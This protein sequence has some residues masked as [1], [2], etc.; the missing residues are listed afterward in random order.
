MVKKSSTGT[1]V[2][3]ADELN[4]STVNGK[5]ASSTCPLCSAHRG[6]PSDHSLK[7]DITTGAGFCHHCH[8]HVFVTDFAEKLK[9]L[10]HL[11]NKKPEKSITDGITELDDVCRDYLENRS[12][13]PSVAVRTGVGSKVLNGIH[14]LAFP[15]MENGCVVNVQYKRA[16][17]EHKEFKFVPGAKVI[18]WNADCLTKGD[19]SSPL[20]ITEGMMDAIAL[21]QSGYPNVVSV[22]NGAGSR[23]QVFDDYRQIIKK[24]FSHIVFAGDTD[25]VGMKLCARVKDYFG[26]EEVSVVKWLCNDFCCKDANDMLM[27]GGCDAVAFCIKNAAFEKCSGYEV[28]S[29]NDDD[30]QLLYEKG[31]PEGRGVGLNALDGII[32]YLPGYMYVITGY[33]GAGKSALVNFITMKL[34]KQ[35][36]WRTLF[37]TPEKTPYAHHK[38]EL[39]SVLTGKKCSRQSLSGDD[40]KLAMNY[41][42]GNVLHLNEEVRYLDK[43][44]A[45]AA[46]AVRHHGIKI[47]VID[48]FLYMDIGKLNGL[49]ETT[50]ITEMLSEI[51]MFAQK[52]DVMVFV[53][54]HP[55]KPN[56]NAERPRLFEML[57]EVSGS[58]AFYNCCDVGIVL[59]RDSEKNSML[60]VKCGK[61]RFSY[62]GRLGEASLMYNTENGRYAD[63]TSYGQ[64]AGVDYSNWT[65]QKEFFD[66][67]DVSSYVCDKPFG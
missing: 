19:G 28:A 48:P 17:A 45:C 53:V 24:N 10:P 65:Y 44:L 2:I 50:K 52:Y 62:L 7:I 66:R 6:H 5:E 42:S 40:F 13:D 57:Y 54:A 31:M 33:P 43:I 39:I 41:M 11:E 37:F 14:Y 4:I 23:I 36:G 9:T 59:E 30:V 56:A 34:L 46:D 26:G 16:D 49:S 60:K 27:C 18:P 35:Y 47:L 20:F 1:Y 64:T 32:R 25:E 63:C 8:E 21:I 22:P 61:S 58:T 55:R 12:I 29:C 67:G 3:S 15:F 51:R 38:I